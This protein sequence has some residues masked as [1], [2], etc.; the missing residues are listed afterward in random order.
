MYHIKK[1]IFFSFLCLT[2]SSYAIEHFIKNGTTNDITVSLHPWTPRNANKATVKPFLLTPAMTRSFILNKGQVGV[3]IEITN[4]GQTTIH[5][6]ALQHLSNK[7]LTII[8]ESQSP[9]VKKYRI[10]IKKN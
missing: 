8:D 9:D 1:I 5:P 10:L 6:I 2:I 3:N 7:N 4:G